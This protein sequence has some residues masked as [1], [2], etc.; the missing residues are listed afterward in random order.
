MAGAV[1]YHNT[2][3]NAMVI[4]AKKYQNLL[5]APFVQSLYYG[6]VGV[7]ISNKSSKEFDLSV[8]CCP[9]HID[10]CTIDQWAAEAKKKNLAPADEVTFFKE[11]IKQLRNI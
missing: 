4:F 10:M 1:E 5:A 9:F 11:K 6:C 3:R 2:P 8:L 7:I